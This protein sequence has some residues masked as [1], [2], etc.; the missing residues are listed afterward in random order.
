MQTG[1]ITSDTL[2]VIAADGLVACITYAKQH[3]FLAL[4]AHDNTDPEMPNPDPEPPPTELFNIHNSGAVN[5]MSSV[6]QSIRYSYLTPNNDDR[7]QYCITI[8]ERF[9]VMDWVLQ[10]S[11]DTFYDA[12][13]GPTNN[14]T[15]PSDDAMLAHM[16]Q[17]KQ[18]PPGHLHCVLSSSRSDSKTSL[19]LLPLQR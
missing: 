12:S 17:H 8:N 7:T 4:D 11:P 1:E 14:N 3:K 9:K 5:C 2:T 19:K 18:L 16:M 10:S 6:D 15:S 13:S